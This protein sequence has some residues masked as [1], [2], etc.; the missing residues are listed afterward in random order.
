MEI[1]TNNVPRFTVDGFNVPADVR[2]D[3]DYVDWE[4]VD[5]GTDSAT[6]VQYLGRWLDIGEFMVT[7]IPRWDGIDIDTYFSGTLIRFVDNGDAVV[8]GRVYS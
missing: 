4:A 3:F 1:R 5:A 7:D 8:M 6:F 2:A